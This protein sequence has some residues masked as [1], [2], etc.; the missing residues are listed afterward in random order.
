MCTKFFFARRV[1]KFDASSIPFQGAA[2]SIFPESSRVS[3]AS[4]A[5]G[6]KASPTHE[7]L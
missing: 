7:Y 2:E 1:A 3:T 5:G 4:S 6:I